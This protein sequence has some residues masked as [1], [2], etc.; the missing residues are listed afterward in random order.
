[1]IKRTVV[2]VAAGLILSCGG[3]ESPVLDI[4]PQVYEAIAGHDFYLAGRTRI[5]HVS[6]IHHFAPS[7]YDAGSDG[8]AAFAGNNEGRT[9]LY[10]EQILE[11]LKLD[12]VALSV[13]AVVISGDLS[14]LGTL[15]THVD[16]ARILGGFEEAGIRVF[17]TPGN[18]DIN[19]P[20][21]VRIEGDTALPVEWTPPGAFRDIYGE[22]G[23]SESVMQH[24]E[25]LSYLVDLDDTYS[26]LALDSAWYQDNAF[27]GYSAS[28][29]ILVDSLY[30]WVERALEYAESRNRQV[31]VMSHHNLLK[32]YEI[33]LDLADF[34]VTDDSRML[35][36]LARGGVHLALSG[37]IHKSDIKLEIVD[38]REFHGMATTAL[39]LYPHSYRLIGLGPHEIGISTREVSLPFD[40]ET[41][42][43]ILDYNRNIGYARTYEGQVARLSRD[44]NARDAREMAEYF[45]L[46]NLYAQQGLERYIPEEVLNSTGAT[47]FSKSG[48][49][50]RGF[51]DALPLD[52][53]PDDR[54]VVI[55][56]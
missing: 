55:R 46:V 4:D 22:F 47:I 9:V 56:F 28:T 35:K 26:L 30:E 21:A 43:E 54:D 51:M 18:H 13:D 3:A 41:N 44:N 45:H 27:L 36:V 14:I 2:I 24:D 19:N 50:M 48:S 29:G 10:T 53:P 31:I 39:P 8:F 15:E 7:L 33:D 11:G 32:H 52:S 6:D 34:V 20:N 38:G 42:Q 49:G 1:L 23:F 40:E 37:H 17:V 25:S 12:L 5:A 16:V